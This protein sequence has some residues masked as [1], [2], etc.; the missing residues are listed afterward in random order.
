MEASHCR[1]ELRLLFGEHSTSED[2]SA[3][4]IGQKQLSTSRN[5][6]IVRNACARNKAHKE[7]V[8]AKGKRRYDRVTP[9]EQPELSPKPEAKMCV[10]YAIR[11]A[12]KA[13]IS[14]PGIYIVKQSRYIPVSEKQ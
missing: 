8:S 5:H 10:I 13:G 2:T 3:A 9:S 7:K 1:G 6:F 11:E 14:F 12:W 4:S